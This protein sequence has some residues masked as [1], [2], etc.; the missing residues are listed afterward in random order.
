M[1]KKIIIAVLIL[2]I[3]GIAVGGFLFWKKSDGDK[4][5]NNKV[6]NEASDTLKDGEEL[7]VGFACSDVS[8]PYF[9]VLQK[10]LHLEVEKEGYSLLTKNAESNVE[11]QI[12][13]VQELIDEGVSL[14]FISPVDWEEITPALELLNEAGIP[15]V[16]LDTKVRKMDLVQ[17]YVGT[18]NG[19]A[20][21]LC[22]TDLLERCPEGGKVA[23]IDSSGVNS[24]MERITG[25]EKKIA[26]KG[27]E[28]VARVDTAM[29][30]E[31]G[32]KA[33]EQILSS[34]DD[35][36]IV[37]CA[38]DQVALGA[39]EAAKAAG[40]NNI[41]IY[42]VDGSPDFKKALSYAD[43]LLAGTAAQSPIGIG[44][45]AVKVAVKILNGDEYKKESYVDVYFINRE[46][47][48]LYGTDGW[49]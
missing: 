25:F 31:N 46:N 10:M 37:M 40:K 18:D 30:Q 3:L 21:K 14:V 9:A 47:V 8:N 17:A 2:F 26:K 24:I 35:V 11:L 13:Q 36:D 32:K 12:Q 49:Q 33:M 28:I 4:K 29:S 22:G 16:N 5:S 38:N 42:G 41:L 48:S 45:K 15:I 34:R 19:D 27:F 20:G 43:T 6:K 39:M 44:E 1:K 7:I 23:I